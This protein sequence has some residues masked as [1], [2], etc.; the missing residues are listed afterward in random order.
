MKLYGVRI[1]IAR[2]LS[3]TEEMGVKDGGQRGPATEGLGADRRSADRFAPLW[4]EPEASRVGRPARVSRAEVVAAAV[5][6][7]DEQGLDKV[8]MRAVAKRLGVGTMTLYSHVP[9]RV[10]LVDAM[11]DRAYADVELPEPGL[12]WRSALAAHARGYW[13]LLRAHTWL[14]DI[15]PWRLPLGPHTM[16]ADEA[17]YRC[18]IDTGLSAD[19]VVETVS[20][21]LNTALGVARSAVAEAD[22]ETRQG[23]DYEGY[24]EASGAFWENHFDP[25]RFPSM[26]RLWTVGAFDHAA[27]PFDLRLDGLL[28]TIELLIDD[29]RERGVQPVPDFD[30]CMGRIDA[31]IAEV[32]EAYGG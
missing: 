23:I 16:A 21:V 2:E 30:E 18:L 20:I 11:I 27:T 6:L 32:K 15:N 25:T 5:G 13:G 4:E 10:E 29:A 12:D 22:D 31:R 26:T 1:V 3:T 14:L 19:Q 24:W 28:D 8:S 7:A 9:G 17:G